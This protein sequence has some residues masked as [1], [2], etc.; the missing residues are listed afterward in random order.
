MLFRASGRLQ[1][2]RIGLQDHPV[3]VGLGEDGG[4]DPLAERVVKRLV[5]RIDGH[6]QPRGGGPV[7]IDVGRQALA[8]HVAGDV[9]HFMRLVQLLDHLGGPGVDVGLGGAFQGELVLGR[10]DI[11][12]DGQ[13]LHRLQIEG[14]AGDIPG[15]L[16][17]PFQNRRLRRRAL[18]VRRQIDQHPAVVE[19]VVGPVDA[20]EGRQADHVRVLEQRGRQLLLLQ[21]VPMRP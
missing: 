5:D 4:D 10:A 19:G 9:A 14:D 13:V 15:A 11:G 20:D 18:A 17:Q 3:L 7:D 1:Q 8:L 12:V 16:T 2:R 6:P 21:L